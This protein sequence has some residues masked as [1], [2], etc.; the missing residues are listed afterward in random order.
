MD[1]T[2]TNPSA[3]GKRKHKSAVNDDDGLWLRP[4]RFFPPEKPTG[5]EGLME[6]TDLKDDMGASQNRNNNAH[7]WNWWWV[8]AVSLIP[9]IGVAYRSIP[10]MRQ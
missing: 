4:Q 3:P 6:R 2:P 8:Y 10:L 9:L 7:L 1:W 5:L